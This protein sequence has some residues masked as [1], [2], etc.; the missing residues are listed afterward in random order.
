MTAEGAESSDEEGGSQAKRL[1]SGQ[2]PVP[3]QI[4]NNIPPANQIPMAPMLGSPFLGMGPMTHYLGHVPMMGAMPQMHLPTGPI[5]SPQVNNKP[6]FQSSA[7]TS[8]SGNTPNKP[9]FAAYGYINVEFSNITQQVL[10]CLVCLSK[11]FRR[12]RGDNR[13]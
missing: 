11:Q 5:A 3:D 2:P 4:P 9:A 12:F 7:G 6:I 13:R 8:T 1:K 10:T